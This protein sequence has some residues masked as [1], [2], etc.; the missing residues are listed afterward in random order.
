MRMH[1]GKGAGPCVRVC[2]LHMY[3]YRCVPEGCGVGAR[4]GW[5]APGRVV[6]VPMNEGI[7]GQA[8]PPAGSE[9]LNVHLRV[10]GSMEGRDR[11]RDGESQEGETEIDGW[12]DR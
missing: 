10:T 11:G 12:T 8:V 4:Q 9:I 2:R 7:E 6:P 5:A 1:Q 3:V